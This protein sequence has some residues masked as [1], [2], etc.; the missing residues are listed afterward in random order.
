[1][2]KQT[3]LTNHR[4]TIDG[5]VAVEP[6]MQMTL[7]LFDTNND[8]ILDFYHRCMEALGGLITHYQAENMKKRA[9]LNQRALTMIPTWVKHPKFDK[10]YYLEFYGCDYEQGITAANIVFHL[11]FHE[12]ELFTP[13]N[14]KIRI[15]NTKQLA[16]QDWQI[17]PW[18][19]QLRV[20]LPLDHPL[21]EPERFLSWI[22]EFYSVQTGPFHSA[23]C[24]FGF[25][26]LSEASQ[27]SILG[28]MQQ[29]LCSHCLRY[30]G[31]DCEISSVITKLWRYALDIHPLALPLI[32]RVNWLSMLNDTSLKA[33]GGRKGLKETLMNDASIQVDDLARGVLIKAGKAPQIGDVGKGD[34]IPIFCTV[35]K[36]LRPLRYDGNFAG[37]GRGFSD[38]AAAE[39]LDAFDKEYD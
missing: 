7:Y 22:K 26:F 16:A 27:G 9:K 36:A 8:G 23:T 18:T 28:P 38:D 34:I 30:P 20:T 35:A 3:D 32:K 1:M 37:L 4:L 31:Y 19:S 15:E 11:M 25:N 6:C 24:G 10:V 12:P 2:S 33:L 14:E 17:G 21:S 5:V 29:W 39:W 13:E